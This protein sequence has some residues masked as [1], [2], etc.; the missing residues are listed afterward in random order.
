MDKIFKVHKIP[1]VDLEICTVEQ[2]IAYNIA[3]QIRG[4]LIYRKEW[5]EMT[6]MNKNNAVRDLVQYYVCKHFPETY[7]KLK[8]DLDLV[9]VILNRSIWNYINAECH[10]FTN[11]EEIGNMFPVPKDCVAIS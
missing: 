6:Y 11:Y 7:P 8:C 9:F 3:S 2:K 10:I 4:E 5:S 1:K